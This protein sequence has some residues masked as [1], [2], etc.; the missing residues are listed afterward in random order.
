MNITTIAYYYVH[1]RSAM[2]GAIPLVACVAARVGGV[3]E[4]KAID[5]SRRGRTYRTSPSGFFMYQ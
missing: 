4:Y 2:C 3:F 1:T 5:F